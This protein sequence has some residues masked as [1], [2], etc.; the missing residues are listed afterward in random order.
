[1]TDDALLALL[2]YG[3]TEVEYLRL[4]Q[5]ALDQGGV[6]VACQDRVAMLLGIDSLT[7]A[8]GGVMAR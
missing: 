8:W 5:L 4:A 2:P 6:D 3:L 1:M 7:E